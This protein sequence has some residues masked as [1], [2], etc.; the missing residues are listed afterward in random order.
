MDI[1]HDTKTLNVMFVLFEV[2]VI[3]HKIIYKQ[4]RDKSLV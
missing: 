2:F 1:E 4:D 3:S